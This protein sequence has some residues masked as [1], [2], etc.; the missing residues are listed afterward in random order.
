YPN[1]DIRYISNPML[2]R[3]ISEFY[4]SFYA[5]PYDIIFKSHR[6]S[7]ATD[8]LG[9]SLSVNYWSVVGG[10]DLDVMPN[11]N[12]YYYNNE[13]E[14][15]YKESINHATQISAYLEEGSTLSFDL[16]GEIG[17]YDSQLLADI[18]TGSEY[19]AL[20][21]NTAMDNYEALE[22][23]LVELYDNS[24]TPALI[25]SDYIFAQEIIDSDFTLKID[26]PEAPNLARLDFKP[27]FRTD[28][29]YDT[30]NAIEKPLLEFVEWDSIKTSYNSDG[31]KVMF[32]TLENSLFTEAPNHEIAYLLNNNLEYLSPPEG[33][34]FAWS[35]EAGANGLE[36]YVLQIPESFIDP[37]NPSVES[38]FKD[39]DSFFVKYDSHV[40]KT[41]QIG[42]EGLYF[43]KKPFNYINYETIAEVLLINTDD[44]TDYDQFTEPYDYDIQ[45]PIT[46]FQT[47]Y[48][49]NYREL[50]VDIDLNLIGVEHVVDGK[51]DFSNIVISV[52]NPAFE[53]TIEEIRIVQETTD[54][55]PHDSGFSDNIWRN[56]EKEIII[57]GTSPSTDKYQL[58]QTNEP[59]FYNDA[60]QDKWLEYITIYDENGNYYTAG[61]QGDDHQLIWD[62][63]TEEFTWNEAF[64]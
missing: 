22:K 17:G 47:E 55:F 30:N 26:L 52:P 15:T 49:G 24:E 13:E 43:Q 45:I 40:V 61:T 58:T 59:L 38:T 7:Y 44:T 23:V 60:I 4:V 39:G 18:Q 41:I 19:L 27:F 36:T 1:W 9:G 25:A 14:S 31:N 34:N 63:F 62:S 32:Y 28:A 10:E 21:I 16:A 8:D 54:A 51:I 35:L 20:Y 64:N 48:L 33:V 56:T 42:I 6:F 3:M 2:D 12:A 11:F 50:T 37:D 46:P 29:E 5:Q 53:L 57:S